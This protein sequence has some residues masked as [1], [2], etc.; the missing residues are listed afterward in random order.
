MPTAAFPNTERVTRAHGAQSARLCAPYATNAL[1]RD[2]RPD[3]PLVRLRIRKLS[4]EYSATCHHRYSSL[5]KACIDS[6]TFL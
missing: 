5:R 6:N 3:Q 1:A 2:T 4:K